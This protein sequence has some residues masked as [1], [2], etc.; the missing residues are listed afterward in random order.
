VHDGRANGKAGRPLVLVADDDAAIRR[1]LRDGLVGDGFRCLGCADGLQLMHALGLVRP[2]L[3]VLDVRMPRLDGHGVLA[4]LRADPAL[5]AVP[6][7]ATSAQ[8]DAGPLLAAGCRAF[9]PKPFDLADLVGA[10]RAALA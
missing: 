1:L 10:V 7:V 6:V 5:R 2:A 3:I 8:A 9:V 4:R